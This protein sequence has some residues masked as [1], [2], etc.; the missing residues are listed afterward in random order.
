[1]LRDPELN[2]PYCPRCGFE[3]DELGIDEGPSYHPK[4]DVRRGEQELRLSRLARRALAGKPPSKV[5]S[6][7]LFEIR[8]CCG[9]VSAPPVVEKC[10][11]IIAEEALRERRN[12][13]RVQHDVKAFAISCV[14]CAAREMGWD[15]VR[16]QSY[17]RSR[18][19]N[20]VYSLRVLQELGLYRRW[21]VEA[22][23]K[24]VKK[25]AERAAREVY[26]SVTELVRRAEEAYRRLKGE[27]VERG[28]RPTTQTLALLSVWE[29][30]RSLGHS[31]NLADLSRRLGFGVK[32]W[33]VKAL[34][35]ADRRE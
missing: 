18:K 33:K 5:L 7:A 11:R 9:E 24:Y 1:M 2:I 10:A 14:L 28:R 23:L 21:S 16:I 27:M 15:E 19:A 8:R 31:G 17:A 30:L 29:A 20:L 3:P 26:A 35:L 13:S 34:Y 32:F 4:E 25:V 6:D 22:E 12:T